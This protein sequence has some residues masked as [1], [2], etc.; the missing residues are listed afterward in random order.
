ML[1][2]ESSSESIPDFL[3][4]MIIYLFNFMFSSGH[5]KIYDFHERNRLFWTPWLLQLQKDGGHGNAVSMYAYIVSKITPSY[6][7]QTSELT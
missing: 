7:L 3:C 6:R 1:A 4:V 5:W 2:E